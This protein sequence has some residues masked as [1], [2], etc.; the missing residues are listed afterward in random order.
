MLGGAYAYQL[1]VVGKTKTCLKESEVLN[2]ITV[3][4]RLI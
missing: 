1:E 2:N 4:Q 3:L